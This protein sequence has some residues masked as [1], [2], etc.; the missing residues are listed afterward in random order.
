MTDSEARCRQLGIVLS[1]RQQY[2]CEFLEQRGRK[3]AVHFGT[4]NCEQIAAD[5]WAREMRLRELGYIK[6]GH[7]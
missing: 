2:A 1:L 3:F 7:T 5:E 4:N 6:N